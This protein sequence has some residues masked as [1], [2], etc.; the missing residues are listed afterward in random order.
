LKGEGATFQPIERLRVEK[1]D[2]VGRGKSKNKKRQ[3]KRGGEGSELTGE[4]G[5]L[6]EAIRKWTRKE[7]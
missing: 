5:I 4:R 7:E 6:A 2:T 3:N 1:E